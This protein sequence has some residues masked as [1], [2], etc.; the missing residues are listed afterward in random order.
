M[1]HKRAARISIIVCMDDS[2]KLQGRF[3]SSERAKTKMFS[4]EAS[5]TDQFFTGAAGL[6]GDAR[7][8]GFNRG[9]RIIEEQLNIKD[10]LDHSLSHNNIM[11]DISFDEVSIVLPNKHVYEV[12]YNRLGNDML[13][14][15]PAIFSVKDVLYNQP[16][17][18]PLTDP[19]QEFAHC[20]SGNRTSSNLAIENQSEEMT[21]SIYGA[22]PKSK[23]PGSILIHTD[24]CV[25]LSLNRGHVTVSAPSKGDEDTTVYFFVGEIDKLKL[26]TAVRL[27]RDPEM[28]L[29]SLN[30]HDARVAFGPSLGVHDSSSHDFVS[31][32]HFNEFPSPKVQPLFRS[33]DF[34][35]RVWP[36][37]FDKELIRLTTKILFDSK[38]NFK[39]IT[40]ALFLCEGS[41]VVGS[42]TLQ[43]VL[44]DWL[45]EYFTV[46]EYP[47]MGYIPPAIM[48]EMHFDVRHSTV[49]ITFLTPGQISFT[50][51]HVKVNCSLLDTGTDVN[52][53]ISAEDLGLF[54]SRNETAVSH[55]KSSI[56]ILDID[57]LDTT[58]NLHEKS[59]VVL[60]VGLAVQLMR[61]RTCNDALM[62]LASFAASGIIP[63]AASSRGN[64]VPREEA[65][66]TYEVSS[67]VVPDLADAM[68]ELEMEAEATKQKEAEN[69]KLH[70]GK[71]KVAKTK[72]GSQVF[73]F[74][75]EN[76][77]LQ[78]GIPD[79]QS[80]LQNI[81]FVTTKLKFRE[82]HGFL[83]EFLDFAEYSQINL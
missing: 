13:L 42:P 17:I 27:E 9:N 2:Q 16:L 78:V 43:S 49:D 14:W 82:T 29:L 24:T 71:S 31:K 40:L 4:L 73:F 41:V 81:F 32:L 74:P 33:S 61:I 80:K 66:E 5:T 79:F 77:K 1:G 69:E 8:G 7:K 67:D 3:D 18:N 52:I 19:D 37:S 47:V 20:I 34:K 25:S 56:C 15:L 72:T 11:V 50:M 48:T 65:Q 36:T 83:R 10:N 58:V 70:K 62:L 39:T 38:T 35:S 75:D 30:V 21:G 54:I 12:I 51:G 44:I 55:L 76:A 23:V 68:A 63:E 28:C 57:S 46:V 60:D 26:L 59:K 6:S 45:S 22:F 64:S 53:T